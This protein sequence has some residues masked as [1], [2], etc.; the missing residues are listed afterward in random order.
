MKND[1]LSMKYPLVIVVLI[2]MILGV[3]FSFTPSFLVVFLFF[4]AGL[5]FLVFSYL[6]PLSAF[7]IV[8]FSLAFR[9][10]AINSIKIG[11]LLI[12]I[13]FLAWI[14]RKILHKQPII[15]KNPLLL[16][17]GCFLLSAAISLMN[18]THLAYSLFDLARYAVS[19]V[20]F[21]M[22]VDIADSELM[23]KRTVYAF[24]CGGLALAVI[25][26]I[27]LIFLSFGQG[28]IISD[29]SSRI[30][31]LYQGA[32]S[33]GHFLFLPLFFAFGLFSDS[34]GNVKRVYFVLF[35][36][37]LLSLFLTISRSAMLG[38]AIGIFFF[39]VLL[40]WRLLSRVLGLCFLVFFLFSVIFGPLYV[41]D[42]F[43]ESIGFYVL[44]PTPETDARLFIWRSNFR[45]ISDHPFVGVGIGNFL[46]EYERY[47]LPS[48]EGLA[49]SR[50]QMGS[51]NLFL[52][53]FAEQG[54]IG[55]L[56][57]MYIF[58]KI[59]IFLHE[60]LNQHKNSSLEMVS[61]VFY[62]TF[63]AYF[64]QGFF[65]DFF[66]FRHLWVFFGLAVV[67]QGMKGSRRVL[68]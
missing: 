23:V 27:I 36:L 48:A 57:V 28:F 24:F 9:G 58:F 65:I 25:S 47:K 11:D 3:L 8:I 15:K 60:N 42:I 7:L 49:R 12:G 55:F 10:I 59:F 46:H 52:E 67:L 35:L 29:L 18:T 1:F 37:L 63:F 6:Q 34:K 38:F 5:A 66:H 62:C 20:L 41:I 14:Y 17:I 33:L 50:D 51:H 64:V 31:S 68:V 43:Q 40:K 61:R 4:G 32:A 45:A 44:R 13:F 54:I 26:L 21:I 56:I 16:A 39:F 53:S 22:V 19:I 2:G 30:I